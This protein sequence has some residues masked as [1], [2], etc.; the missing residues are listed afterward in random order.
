[1]LVLLS[2]CSIVLT[3]VPVVYQFD[4][5]CT[6]EN[7]VSE[8]VRFLVEND[9]FVIVGTD[10]TENEISEAVD[11]GCVIR[12]G[13]P[14][15]MRGVVKEIQADLDS[16]GEDN[17]KRM[18]NSVQKKD[19]LDKEDLIRQFEDLHPNETWP[20]GIMAPYQLYVTPEA[21]AVV[22]LAD[23]L[24]GVEEIYAEALS[25][26][27]VSE[28]VLFGVEERW[29]MPEVLLEESPY[30]PGN[31]SP[32]YVV[33]DCEDQ[34]NAL[35]SI[36]IADGYDVENVRVV[37]GMV[38]FDGYVGGHAWV[39]VQEEGR[40]FTLEATMGPYYDEDLGVVV[41]SIDVPYGYFKYHTYPALEVWYYYNNEY[42][43]NF[44]GMVGNAPPSWRA[45]VVSWLDEDLSNFQ[46][47]KR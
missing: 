39:E 47:R 19:V 32:G 27:W 9:E 34:A 3:P 38:D 41:D 1:M 13:H 44:E 26:I 28:E 5:S 22:E 43:L 21:D 29:L 30:L 12:Y 31:P 7:F 20:G 11:S 25:W 2:G 37:L 8:E 40:W 6:W 35:A 45:S 10:A 4:S 15:E 23:S 33:S 36:L 17:I 16:S 42:F 18:Q 46:G 24:D 14:L